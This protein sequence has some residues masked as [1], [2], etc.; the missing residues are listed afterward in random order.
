MAHRVRGQITAGTATHA[1]LARVSVK[2]LQWALKAPA[3]DA[4]KLLAAAKQCAAFAAA[5]ERAAKDVE[6][7]AIRG[8]LGMKI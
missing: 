4:H 5:N 7:A 1:A 3:G 8:N 6:A 2:D